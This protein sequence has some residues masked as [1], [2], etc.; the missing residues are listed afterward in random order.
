MSFKKENIFSNV[1]IF[2]TLL[3][4]FLN[5][6]GGIEIQKE[7]TE[8]VQ[9]NGKLTEGEIYCSKSG[10]L[11][12][13]MI[14]HACGPTW[15]G[16]QNQEK[17]CLMDCIQAALEETEKRGYRSIAVP[18]LCTGIFGF[19]IKE[20]TPVIVKAVKS[21]LK[22]KKDSKIK[23]IFLCDVKTNT[24][25]CFSEALQQVYNGKVNIFK[26]NIHQASG[27]AQNLQGDVAKGIL[28]ILVLNCCSV[29][30]FLS[31]NLFFP[32]YYFPDKWRIKINKSPIVEYFSHIFLKFCSFVKR[33]CLNYWGLVNRGFS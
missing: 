30:P 12:C 19:P 26:R 1:S 2:F 21:F 16:G 20:A 33:L 13:K 29:Q 18:A 14:V 7:C 28:R 15:K 22:D 6:T 5:F 31:T 9:K 23:E 27:P 4:V 10:T 8:H 32:Y 25:Q 11:S 17:D 24:V 3:C